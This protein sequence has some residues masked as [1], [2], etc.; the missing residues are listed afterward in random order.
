MKLPLNKKITAFS[1]FFMIQFIG[2]LFAATKGTIAISGTVSDIPEITITS[3]AAG[4]SIHLA[5]DV[6]DMTVAIVNEKSAARSCYT[7]TLSSGSAEESKGAASL[8]GSVSANCLPYT[9]KYG[10][11]EVC[12]SSLG[13]AMV[14]N[15][16]AKKL[17]D[18]TER[19]VVVSY[20][21]TEYFLAA[22]TYSDTINVTIAAK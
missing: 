18:D 12:F 8:R 11:A 16:N 14:S 1:A 9:V 10:G 7:V 4:S 20:T 3:E 22:D 15:L 21:G 19:L 6:T 17:T 2:S 13:C 5:E